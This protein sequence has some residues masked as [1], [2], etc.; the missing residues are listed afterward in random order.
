AVRGLHALGPAALHRD[1][2]ALLERPAGPRDPAA[3]PRLQLARYHRR[4]PPLGVARRIPRAGADAGA[5]RGHAPQVGPRARPDARARAP[6]RAVVRVALCL[7]K[8]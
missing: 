1:P 5:G 8:L 7:T 3:G 2:E 4:L 6:A